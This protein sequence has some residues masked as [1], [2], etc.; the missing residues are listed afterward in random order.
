MK[1][2]KNFLNKSETVRKNALFIYPYR[3]P[4]KFQFYNMAPPVGLEYIATAVKPL[5]TELDVVD[6][7]YEKMPIE[8]FLSEKDYVGFGLNWDHQ[9]KFALEILKQVEENSVVIWGGLY[10]TEQA[11]RLMKE[12]PRIDILVKAE[13][14][15]AA[16][17]IFSGMPLEDVA[18]ILYRKKGKIITTRDRNSYPK[19]MDLFPDRS[20]RRYSYE[21]VAP[22]GI[23]VG[24]DTIMTSRGC[25]FSCE[26][27]THRFD[28]DG[29]IRRWSYR[30]AENVVAEIK[31]IT[32]QII[33]ISDDDFTVD[34]KRVEKICDLLIEQKIK[35]IFLVES[36][37]E[38]GNHPELIAKMFKAGFRFIAYGLE[39]AQDK[40][41]KRIGKGFS[42]KKAIEAFKTINKFPILSYGFFIV[43]YIHET[44]EEALEIAEFA[45]ELNLD[46]INTAKLKALEGSP[47]R[48]IVKKLPGYYIDNDTR[49]YSDLI[50]KKEVYDIARQ[51]RR[52]FYTRHQIL[53]IIIKITR[54]GLLFRKAVLQSL[55]V[56]FIGD[57]VAK[58]LKKNLIKLT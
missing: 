27:C 20:L 46:F 48:E 49:V 51:I 11:E 56:I 44:R 57:F 19:T 16:M 15:S 3:K 17:E 29:N 42:K 26:F 13:G 45:R 31:Q 14:E 34:K 5:V 8:T 28:S 36:R 18:G 24:F 30:S 41:L 4:D 39:S 58:K 22:L 10:A 21:A 53:Q 23:K 32:A 12:N 33:G 47:L 1:R 6:M 43:G 55:W 37:I 7:R 9:L 2:K 50:S 40:T 54:S 38:I 25:N 35:K 52:R